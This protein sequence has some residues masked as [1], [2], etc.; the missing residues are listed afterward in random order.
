MELVEPRCPECGTPFNPD[1]PRTVELNS[2]PLLKFLM[3]KNSVWTAFPAFLLICLSVG[4]KFSHN[5]FLGALLIIPTVVV[6]LVTL[7]IWM[8]RARFQQWLRRRQRE[9]DRETQSEKYKS[10]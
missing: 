7:Y 10:S 4:A 1:D 6:V 3:K 8:V 5:P 2:T 9:R